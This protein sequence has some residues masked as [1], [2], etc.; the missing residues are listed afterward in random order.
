MFYPSFTITSQWASDTLT[1]AQIGVRAIETFRRLESISP[2][3]RTWTLVEDGKPVPL[4]AATARMTSVVEGSLK[5][6]HPDRRDNPSHGYAVVAR[7]AQ[8]ESEFGSAGTAHLWIT[9]GAKFGDR[10][11]FAIGD[12]LF[13]PDFSLVTYPLYRAS[14]ETL[15]SIWP[16]PWALAYTF[17]T[18]TPPIDAKTGSGLK[19]QSPFEVAWI[20]YLSPALAL[21]LEPPP[22]IVSERTPGGGMILSA[23]PGLIDPQNPDHMRR[24]RALQA[25]M[26]ERVGTKDQHLGPKDH[27]AREGP[28]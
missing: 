24:S 5:W 7:G 9:A 19:R 21:G 15:A 1:P 2:A 16:V 23:A 10:I 4:S 22:E 26:T 27:A 12:I 3:M 20:A 28:Y 11:S 17:S 6:K 13:P 18:E 14:L 8:V 25:I